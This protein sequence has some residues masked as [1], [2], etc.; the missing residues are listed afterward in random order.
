MCI[1]LQIKEMHSH[2]QGPAAERSSVLRSKFAGFSPGIVT[3][4]VS[5]GEP[6]HTI[7]YVSLVVVN[8]CLT[9]YCIKADQASM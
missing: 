4:K 6:H 2:R 8:H 1:Y 5:Q 3:G 9:V 7:A